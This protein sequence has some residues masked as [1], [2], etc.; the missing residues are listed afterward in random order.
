MLKLVHDTDRPKAT[1]LPPAGGAL[2]LLPGPVFWISSD[3]KVTDA[4]LAALDL[5]LDIDD[6][7]SPVRRAILSVFATNLPCQTI[8]V[9]RGHPYA[10]QVAPSVIAE[11]D[12][13]PCVVAVGQRV[14]E[15]SVPPLPTASQASEVTPS[16]KKDR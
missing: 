5:L 10:F 1:E 3:G 7:A 9:L 12:G 16:S 8:A 13:S 6:D 14:P 4:N 15:G 2:A 11:S